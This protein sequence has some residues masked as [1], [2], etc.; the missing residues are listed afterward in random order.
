MR[1]GAGAGLSDV[2]DVAANG[3]HPISACY[4]PDSSSGGKGTSLLVAAM[5]DLQWRRRRVAITVIGT[6]LVFAMGLLMSGL[7]NAFTV[8]VTRTLHQTGGDR[9]VAPTGA[10][11]PFSAGVRIPLEALAAAG[12]I[13]GVERA[14][15]LLFARSVA[16]N[17]SKSVDVDIFGVV[18]GGLGAPAPSKGRLPKATGEAMTA[19]NLA[20]V[21]DK[22]TIGG[23]PFTVVG[24]VAKASLLAGSPSVFLRLEDAQAVVTNGANLA[25]MIVTRGVPASLPEGLTSFD[26]HQATSDLSRPLKNA[27]SS[28]QFIKVLLWLVAAL[29]VASVVYLS[30]LER[31]RDFAVFKATGMATG[32]I[33]TGVMLQAVV[34]AVAA[35]IVGGIVA[36]LLAPQF[37]MEVAIST[38]ALL[39]MPVLAVIVGVLASLVG[40]RRI[41]RIDPATSFGGP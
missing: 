3:S 39:F 32:A 22:I 20:S 24:T 6:A 4:C 37:P 25:S 14:D 35:S 5:R 12:G 23:Q 15:P 11:G 29:I 27:T 38:G 1:M 13:Q 34:I 2:R 26:I 40:V 7:S 41:M 19:A 28:I 33:A 17:G 10:V 18:D 30:A 21:G 16:V 9:W 36:V 8:E 31:S